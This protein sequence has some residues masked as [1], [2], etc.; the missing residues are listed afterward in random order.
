MSKNYT[1]KEIGTENKT[2]HSANTP[3][4]VNLT[5]S[6]GGLGSD[7]LGSLLADLGRLSL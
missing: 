6:G 4:I 5:S 1:K 3:Y 2:Q 7:T